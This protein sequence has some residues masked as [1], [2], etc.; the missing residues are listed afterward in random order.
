MTNEEQIK[1]VESGNSDAIKAFIRK[2]CFTSKAE[3]ALVKRGNHDEIMM[4]LEEKEISNDMLVELIHRGNTVELRQAFIINDLKNPRSQNIL[5]K[6]N[7]HD[8]I[9]LFIELCI[10]CSESVIQILC[11]GEFTEIESCYLRNY[12]TADVEVEFITRASHEQV[13]SYVS[14]F[15]LCHQAEI[16]LVHRGNTEEILEH[17]TYLNAIIDDMEEQDAPK[18]VRQAG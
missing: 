7:N 13:M 1:L 16:E 4:Y 3:A 18:G 12:I 10:P 5:I 14:N 9:M 17:M 15:P 8:L 2:N 6:K 11:R